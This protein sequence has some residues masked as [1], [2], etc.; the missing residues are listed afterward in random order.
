MSLTRKNAQ[1][2]S[3]SGIINK[4]G[5]LPSLKRKAKRSIR[6]N[7]CYHYHH[8]SIRNTKAFIASAT[9]I[10]L[11][12]STTAEYSAALVVGS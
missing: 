12:T 1:V 2:I 10:T 3:D 8:H 11:F 4:H 7:F 5:I 9:P 6:N